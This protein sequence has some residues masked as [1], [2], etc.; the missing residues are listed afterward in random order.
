MQAVQNGIP[1][2]SPAS[3]FSSIL[4]AAELLENFET[5]AREHEEA[6]TFVIDDPSST[7]LIISIDDG[8][9][10]SQLPPGGSLPSDGSI[11]KHGDQTP[12][13]TTMVQ[14]ILSQRLI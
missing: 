3:P 1:R 10:Y 4:Y 6:T 12:K 7:Q 8:T 5:A 2:G 11:P 14:A 9:I 13:S